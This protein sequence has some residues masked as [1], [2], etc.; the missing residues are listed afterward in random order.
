ME[1]RLQA[2]QDLRFGS[3]TAVPAGVPVVAPAAHCLYCRPRCVGSMGEIPDVKR[4]DAA[5][6]FGLR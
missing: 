3:W 5:V 1:E 4:R 2:L 6:G